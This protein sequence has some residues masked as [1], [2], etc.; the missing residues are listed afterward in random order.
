VVDGEVPPGTDVLIPIEVTPT[1]QLEGRTL[2]VEVVQ[3]GHAETGGFIAIPYEPG[4]EL[5]RSAASWITAPSEV[6]LEPRETT[7]LE[8]GM[9]VP[10][11]ARGTHAAALLLSAPPPE[12]AEGLRLTLRVLI[13]II[14][15]TEGRPARQ[16]VRLADAQ[17]RY[18]LPEPD[19]PGSLPDPD[20]FPETTLVDALIENN[21]GTFSS[22][23]GD[24]WVDAKD[25]SGEWR[26]IRRAEIPATR[27]LPESAI[28]MPVDLG[29]L[30][31]TGE[32]RIRGELYVDGRRTRP[33]R[34]EVAFEGH[35]EVQALVTDIDL[36]VEPA[37]FEYDYRPGAARS[38]RIAVT[39]PA[40]DPV[41]V[42]VEVAIPDEM[43]GRASATVRDTDLSAAG[44]IEVQPAQFVL[45]P[46]QTR[47]LRLLARFPD[48]APRQQ[49]YYA[50]LTLSAAYLDGQRAGSA[51][52]LVEVARAGGEDRRELALEAVRVATTE[53]Q[54]DVALGLRATNVGN[55]L[56]RPEVEFRVLD[57]GG[58]EIVSGPLTS[59]I[60]GPLMPLAA[61]TFGGTLS[62]SELPEGELT[63][64]TIVRDGGV[65][66]GE[67]V[68]QLGK[69][70][71]GSLTLETRR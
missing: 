44:W 52:G 60:A 69:A 70:E 22:L 66:V 31:P 3:L 30:L 45:R 40:I 28:S 1:S 63:L 62:V 17:L 35:P 24:V 11:A 32:Y 47:N 42:T 2:D 36:G 41:E 4:S 67:V 8:V 38:G 12:G 51:T 10:L 65:E 27:L 33:L 26:Q 56:L 55:V 57:A 16:D 59:E 13:P 34:R 21:G 64:L 23:R 50:Q 29:R 48:S 14:L 61:R 20:S 9:R 58:R 15:G 37:V 68:Q 25:D 18:R 6:L 53:S 43:A 5:P 7:V 71:D 49:N 19:T 39:N 46:G 54:G